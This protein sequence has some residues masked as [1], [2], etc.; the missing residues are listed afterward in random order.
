MLKWESDLLF[1]LYFRRGYRE[2]FE[3]GRSS[4]GFKENPWRAI[5][6][7]V[8]QPLSSLVGAFPYI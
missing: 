1:P 4:V 5:G 6:M 2:F 8:L 3:R 7:H